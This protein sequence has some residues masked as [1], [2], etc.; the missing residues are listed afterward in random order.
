M[1]KLRSFL[2]LIRCLTALLSHKALDVL[3][4]V[5]KTGFDAKFNSCSSI[6]LFITQL[7]E[8]IKIEKSNADENTIHRA[9][10]KL[11][12]DFLKDWLADNA[13][14]YGEI[15]TLISDENNDLWFYSAKILTIIDNILDL[16]ATLKGKHGVLPS[17]DEFKQLSRSLEMTNSSKRK[18]ERSMANRLHMH[19]MLGAQGNEVDQQ[20]TDEYDD[21]VKNFREIQSDK[22][23]DVLSPIDQFLTNTDTPFSS[24]VK[25]F[26]IKQM[27]QISKLTLEELREIYVNRNILWIKPL[28]Q[29][30]S[31]QQTKNTRPTLIVPMPLFQCREQFERIRK[32]FNNVDRNNELRKIIQECNSTQKLSYAF[33]CWFIEYYSRF[34]QPN[35]NMDVDFVRTIK[36]DVTSDLIKSFTQLCH[37]F[38][39]DLCSNFSDKSYFRLDSNM[40]PDDTHKRLLALN[41]VA[42]FI[43][44][45]SYVKLYSIFLDYLL[46]SFDDQ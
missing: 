32:I 18:I 41:I 42:V 37:Q 33:L 44:F 6:H 46:A 45:K 31:D 25:L 5:C 10:V 36:N 39:I 16:T 22:K 24:T 29:R 27:L 28:F 11:E 21:F 19:L 30:S 14:S 40:S 13:D 15:L 3:K 12:L 9:L 4:D 34:A 20:L 1:E 38:L 23:L 26:I 35:T 43:Y 7:Q 17:N 2:S 8:H